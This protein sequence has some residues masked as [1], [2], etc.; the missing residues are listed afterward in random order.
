MSLHEYFL[1]VRKPLVRSSMGLAWVASPSWLAPASDRAAL[2]L[3]RP[4]RE[5]VSRRTSRL[6]SI[7]CNYSI[8]IILCNK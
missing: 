5:V 4:R 6:P 8:V 1:A 3:L 7:V 2:E